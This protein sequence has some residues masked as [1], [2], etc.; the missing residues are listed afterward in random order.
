[1]MYKMEELRSCEWDLVVVSATIRQLRLYRHLGSA[2]STFVG[3]VGA[4]YQPM[5]VRPGR[6]QIVL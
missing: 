1:M 6:G 4:F 2:F 3:S 5:F